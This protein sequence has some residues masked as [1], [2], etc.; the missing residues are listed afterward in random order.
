MIIGVLRWTVGGRQNRGQ[1]PIFYFIFSKI[2]RCPLFWHMKKFYFLLLITV[3]YASGIVWASLQPG[4]QVNQW[5]G[6]WAVASSLLH[7]PAYAGLAWLLLLTVRAHDQYTQAVMGKV[8][9]A[10]FVFAVIFG[11]MNEYIQALVPGRD[12]SVGDMMFNA[13]GALIG[14]AVS[15]KK[16]KG[17]WHLFLFFPLM[18]LMGTA[19]VPVRLGHAADL[20]QSQ[21]ANVNAINE[22]LT[23]LESRYRISFKYADFPRKPDFLKFSEVKPGEYQRL[24]AYLAL[25]EEEINK[26]PAGFFNEQDIRGIGFVMRLF[27]GQEPAQGLYSPQVRVMFFD[28]SR[29]GKNKAQQRHSIHHEIFH[30]MFQQKGEGFTLLSDET[31]G[32]FNSPEFSYGK[33]T[34][35]LSTVN[36]Y[37][38]H[39]PNQPGFVTYYAM[40]SIQEDQAEVFACL[41][42][43]QHRR[44]IEEWM[45]KDPLLAKKVQAMKEFAAHYHAR[46]DEAYWEKSDE[47]GDGCYM[48][49]IK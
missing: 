48:T 31:W 43:E 38:R 5:M 39:A 7:I 34:K 36:P 26:Y 10:V 27:A 14:L 44:L 45:L 16:K 3:L 22:R 24:D 29:F 12:F 23:R 46:M 40:E 11:V 33:Q 42:L 17:A 18:A 32:S 25:F 37:N 41:M 20:S 19:V 49:I 9:W 35:S 15:F 21:T 47:K 28:I 30:M 4:D 6:W 2:G 13:L 1:R 8:G